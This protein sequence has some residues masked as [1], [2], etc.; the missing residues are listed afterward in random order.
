MDTGEQWYCSAAGGLKEQ[1]TNGAALALQ[2]LS[3]NKL[4]P[5]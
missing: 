5:Y 4:H 2:F 3:L 1:N